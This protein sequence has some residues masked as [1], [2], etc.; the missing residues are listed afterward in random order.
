MILKAMYEDCKRRKKDLS[1]AWIDYHKASDSVPHS[2]VQKSLELAG[3]NSKI[4]RFCKL[5][6][7]KW[8][9]GMEHNA[10]RTN[11]AGSDAVT[12]HS[13]TRRN[14]P[15]GSLPPLLFCAALIPS[16]HELNRADCGYKVHGADRKISHLLYM[17]DLKLLRRRQD[18][19]ENK[20]SIVKAINKDISMNSGFEKC[21]KICLKKGM[22][23]R[24]R[25]TESTFEKGIKELE[26][27]KAYKYL[28]IEDSHAI[29]D[30]M[31]KKS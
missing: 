10:P 9:T 27:R 5:S 19:L 22:D 2:W 1:I 25:Y 17:D 20:I 8:N 28:G 31:R 30:K 16:T 24:N 21:A 14:I 18:E 7:Q 3:V 6:M 15:V 29:Q 4:V 12:T 11:K 23:Q 26:P 13:D